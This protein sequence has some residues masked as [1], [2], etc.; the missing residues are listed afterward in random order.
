MIMVLSFRAEMPHI[1]LHPLFTRLH[2]KM[3]VSGRDTCIM[4]A[5]V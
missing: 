5:Y 4:K 3:D 2:A 1:L